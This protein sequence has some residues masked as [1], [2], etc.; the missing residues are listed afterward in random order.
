[1]VMPAA[2]GAPQAA[3]LNPTGAPSGSSPTQ[4]GQSPGN[5]VNGT[6]KVR[7]AIKLLESALADVG[8]ETELGG[9]IMR[10]IKGLAAKAPANQ[11]TAGAESS[12]L[13]LLAQRARQQA[14]MLALARQQGQSA[15]AGA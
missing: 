14:P 2:P 5:A 9:E 10:S 12:Q 6:A 11:T 1:M 7:Q 13:A 15:G 8:V 4:Q 3:P